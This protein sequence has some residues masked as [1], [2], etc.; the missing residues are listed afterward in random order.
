M[1]LRESIEIHLRDNLI[2]MMISG[3]DRKIANLQSIFSASF[4]HNV[5]P[6]GTDDGRSHQKAYK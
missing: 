5:N 4:E 2:L 1:K 6:N 3:N